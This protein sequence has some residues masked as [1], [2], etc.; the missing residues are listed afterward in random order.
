MLD[1]EI[2]AEVY[3]AMTGGQVSLTLTNNI[4]DF[5]NTGEAGE[6]IKRL[7]AGR[8]PLKVIKANPIEL[9]QHSD[10]LKMLSKTSERGCYW[11]EL[12]K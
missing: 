6:E 12:E 9:E 8:N 1:A 5:A 10:Q 7:S 11:N 3:L 4:N 2:L